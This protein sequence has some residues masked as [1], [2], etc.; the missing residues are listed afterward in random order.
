MIC[1]R[2]SQIAKDGNRVICSGA[3]SSKSPAK[4]GGLMEI[5][6]LRFRYGGIQ[7]ERAVV[8]MSGK[9]RLACLSYEA[10]H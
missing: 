1:Q 2:L 3:G 7:R 4:F 8:S 10:I 6:R 5:S 9:G